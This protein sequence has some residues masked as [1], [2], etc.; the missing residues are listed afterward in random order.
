MGRSSTTFVGRIHLHA[1]LVLRILLS[2][3]E[4]GGVGLQGYA[5]GKSQLYTMS[6]PALLYKNIA[7]TN[8]F[9]PKFD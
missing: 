2:S 8:I 5:A 4:G 3:I 1:I 6:F 7:S 9:Q